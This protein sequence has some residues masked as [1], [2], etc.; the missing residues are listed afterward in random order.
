MSRSSR[1]SAIAKGRREGADLRWLRGYRNDL[2]RNLETHEESRALLGVDR[3]KLNWVEV[4]H[5]ANGNP[6]RASASPD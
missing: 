3:E 1:T 5:D 6:I 4:A 2:D